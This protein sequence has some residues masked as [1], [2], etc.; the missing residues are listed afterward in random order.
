[1]ILNRYPHPVN[2]PAK[3][4]LPTLEMSQVRD[5]MNKKISKVLSKGRFK[6]RQ[7]LT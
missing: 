7:F 2:D 5:K 3:T 1:M 6:G 4:T